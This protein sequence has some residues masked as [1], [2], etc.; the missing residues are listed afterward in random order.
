M[1]VIIVGA[2]YD[3]H[4]G[5]VL[6]N[7]L[8]N[9][10]YEMVGFLD[11]NPELKGKKV[12]GFPVLG[13]SDDFLCI[14][15]DV[16]G[17][18][19]AVGNNT[20]R[21]ELSNKLEEFGLKPIN[22]IHPNAVISDSVKIGNGVFVGPNVIIN[23]GCIIGDCVIINTSASIDHDSIIEDG[24]HIAPGVAIAGRVKIEKCAFI[25]I[26]TS[27]I[28]DITVG[29]YALVG[30]GAAVI[31]D[32]PSNSKSVGVPAKPI[33]SGKDSKSKWV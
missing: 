23:R 10:K 9:K 28:E 13:S 30:A 8:L 1:K 24:A 20:I 22:V 21:L 25:G 17:F 3:A 19:V 26:G 6:D 32:L 11:S 31:N 33:G 16:K 14:P 29:E 7:L 2:R 12:L 18:I 15:K 4:G 5:V 27:I